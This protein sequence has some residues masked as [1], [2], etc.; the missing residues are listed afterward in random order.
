ML[1]A[2]KCSLSFVVVGFC[3]FVFQIPAELVKMAAGA[4]LAG[5]GPIVEILEASSFVFQ[6]GINKKLNGESQ[7]SLPLCTPS[8]CLD[9]SPLPQG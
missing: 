1:A 3:L 4:A 9:W 2:K 5:T 8:Q 6:I 7:G